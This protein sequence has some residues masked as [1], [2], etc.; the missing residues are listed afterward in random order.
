MVKSI[1]ILIF[2]TDFVRF[3]SKYTM[4]AAWK[5]KIVSFSQKI[6]VLLLPLGIVNK[7]LLKI[8]KELLVFNNVETMIIYTCFS[9]HK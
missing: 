3:A 6:I 1:K 2:I 8:I 4:I 7:K 9:F 5:I